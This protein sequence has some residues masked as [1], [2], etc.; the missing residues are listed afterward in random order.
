MMKG[1]R[2]LSLSDIHGDMDAYQIF[3][4]RLEGQSFDVAIIAGDLGGLKEAR[5]ILSKLANFGKPILYVMG[6]WDS[7]SYLD[8]IHEA[9][10]HIHLTHQRIGDWVFLGYSGCSAN[11]YCGN[12]SLAG[13]HEEFLSKARH[14]KRKYSSY[15]LF[16][17]SIVFKELQTYIH[18]NQIDVDELIF[19][20]HDR[21]YALPFTPVLYIF[22]H[23][24]T[25]KYTYYKGIHCLNTS[26][27]SMES[28][29]SNKDMDAPGN[30]CL[31]DL[32]GTAC[33]INFQEI[34][35]PYVRTDRFHGSCFQ[36][37]E[38]NGY[39]DTAFFKKRK[40]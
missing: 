30:F 16:C 19:V 11:L 38:E 25:P 18:E 34:P 2:I 13:K 8:N 23:R 7:F 27:I 40:V 6:N 33:Q 15:E 1:L 32:E 36:D 26:A 31:I 29:M 12:P 9:A 37:V 5:T 3:L 22:G 21:F 4:N 35:S 24:H 10:T 17:K 20:S 28:T 14:Y 39:C